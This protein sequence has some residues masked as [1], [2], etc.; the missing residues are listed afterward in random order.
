[1]LGLRKKC[2]SADEYFE[3]EEIAEY[4][5]EYYHG[6]IF[7]MSG[8]SF[9]HNVI[10]GNVLADL[11][12]SLRISDCF[13]FGS[14]MKVQME[15]AE[16][17]VYPDISIVCGDIRFAP[18]RNDTITNPIVVIEILSESTQEYDRGLKLRSYLKI[19]SL[20]DYILIDQYSY[21]VEYFFKN[22]YHQWAS[23]SFES[24][25]DRLILRSVGV[26]LSLKT[27]YHRVKF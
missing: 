18:R 22:E 3:I 16:Y 7:A 26:G 5:S 10:A 12:P 24:S 1:M 25:D 13:V 14:D 23:E 15:E 4:K 8:A 20:K 9:N 2:I 19:P 6:E 11:H 21:H 17:Y 27:I